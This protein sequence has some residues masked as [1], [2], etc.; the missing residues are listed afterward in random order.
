MLFSA[1]ES[2]IF[3]GKALHDIM[4]DD[5]FTEV[6]HTGWLSRIGKSITGMLVGLILTVGSFP[7]LWWNEGRSVKTYQGLVEGEKVCVEAS[8]EAID[9]ANDGKLVHTSARAEAKDEVADPVFGLQLPGTVKLRRNVEMF[10]WTEQ[11]ST[12]KRTKMGGGEET[13]TE[14]TYRT[15]WDAKM[16]RSSEFHKPTGHS[17]PEPLYRS[18]NF[19]A[20]QV[21]L[22][23]YRLPDF[24][25]AAWND[26]K[27]LSPPAKETLPEALQ[28]RAQLRDNWLYLSANPDEPKL[29]DL[30]IKFESIPAGDASVLVRQIKDT[31]EPYTTKT[32]TKIARIT[33]GVQSKESMFAAAQ[34]ENTMMTWLLRGLGLLLM[35]LGLVCTFQPLKVVADVLPIAGR[36][37]GAG[38]GLIAF[39]LAGIGSS[40]TISLAWLWY[41]PLLG[42][43]ILIVTVGCMVLIIR[44]LSKKSA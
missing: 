36:I 9:P 28:S 3:L 27:P 18:E 44:A 34:S 39:L 40:L 37:V 4:S 17:N 26:Y 2:G 16:H 43:A 5:T 42:A 41:R 1:V 31:F 22:G 21:S 15:E 8:A 6:S 10:Q 7:L 25:I 11:K 20:K 29:G 13:V 30:R 32:E 19:S 23:A 24:L 35:F 14:Y 33:S 38:T 12:K